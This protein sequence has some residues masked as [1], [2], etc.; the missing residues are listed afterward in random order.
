[1]RR[2]PRASACTPRVALTKL[3]DSRRSASNLAVGSMW[4]IW[5]G[6]FSRR[7]VHLIEVGR[8]QSAPGF[9][10]GIGGRFTLDGSH[11]FLDLMNGFVPPGLN[12]FR[13]GPSLAEQMLLR[14]FDTVST[15]GRFL[16]L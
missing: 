2:T 8:G 16:E 3:A 9:L 6:C 13:S 10:I 7:F 14:D 5:S 1:M 15:Q 4:C 11:R 12:H